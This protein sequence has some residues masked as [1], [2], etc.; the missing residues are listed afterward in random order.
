MIKRTLRFSAAVFASFAIVACS[1]NSNAAG[2]DSAAGARAD[3]QPG[4]NAP[5]DTAMLRT[6]SALRRD[7]ATGMS[8]PTD[9]AN[10]GTKP[11]K[12]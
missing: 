3:S 5:S 9:G 7:T 1:G 6:D 2:G 10:R 4:V 12:P 8:M 11:R